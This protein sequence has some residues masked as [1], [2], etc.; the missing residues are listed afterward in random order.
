M[1]GGVLKDLSCVHVY[2]RVS[3]WRCLFTRKF[4]CG[5]YGLKCL[6]FSLSS[7]K[8]LSGASLWKSAAVS[9]FARS[10]GVYLFFSLPS[11][12]MIMYTSE[13]IPRTSVWTFVVPVFPKS[14]THRSRCQ[15]V[16]MTLQSRVN[17]LAFI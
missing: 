4:R 15:H 16:P 13:P 3:V 8:Y 5:I 10:V 14:L 2:G 6:L 11:C 12:F 1:F 9:R 17:R 7:L